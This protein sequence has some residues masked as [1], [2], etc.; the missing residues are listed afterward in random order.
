MHKR[1]TETA[2][3]PCRELI[4]CLKSVIHRDR[5]TLRSLSSIA[6]FYQFSNSW[7][8][9]KHT[10]CQSASSHAWHLNSAAIYFSPPGLMWIITPVTVLV[11]ELFCFLS[12]THPLL[13]FFKSNSKIGEEARTC[14]RLLFRPS[15]MAS[16]P[17]EV[18]IRV[19]WNWWAKAWEKHEAGSRGD[20][21][22]RPLHTHHVFRHASLLVVLDYGLVALLLH[23]G[24]HLERLSALTAENKKQRCGHTWL[25]GMKR[26][27]RGFK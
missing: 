10:T 7:I 15:A 1:D 11:M 3:S 26:N 5:R 4:F 2:Q 12:E 27:F 19:G 18:R 14:T 9:L 23:D 6:L 25:I 21:P 16:L 13:S 20:L 24:Q 17:V 22:D 8:L